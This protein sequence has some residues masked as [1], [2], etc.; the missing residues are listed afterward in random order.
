MTQRRDGEGYSRQ[1]ATRAHSQSHLRFR[2][3]EPDTLPKDLSLSNSSPPKLPWMP[4]WLSLYMLHPCT[5][6]NTPTEILQAPQT[7]QR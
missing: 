3:Q 4:S 1:G 6:E 7:S 5:P 2:A